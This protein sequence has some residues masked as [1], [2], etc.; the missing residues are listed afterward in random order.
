M[1]HLKRTIS[2]VLVFAMMLSMS[3]TVRA[4][5]TISGGVHTADGDYKPGS[6]AGR[7]EVAGKDF[8]A[9]VLDED[10]YEHETINYP[11]VY[12]VDDSTVPKEVYTFTAN[13]G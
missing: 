10:Q 4:V 7:I 13:G 2:L 3:V 12:P 11:T 5:S 8:S 6:Y 9:K 1:K